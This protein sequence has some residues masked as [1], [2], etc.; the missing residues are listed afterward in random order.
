VST[1]TNVQ[2][3]G[4]IKRVNSTFYTHD[5]RQANIAN[6]VTDAQVAGQFLGTVFFTLLTDR[7]GGTRVLSVIPADDLAD[8]VSGNFFFIR[9]KAAP[10]EYWYCPS[11]SS[12][13]GIV[14]GTPVY[15]SR[16]ERTKFRIRLTDES[17]NGKGTIM[18]GTDEITITLTSANLSVGTYGNVNGVLSVG[19]NPELGLE[20]SALSRGFKAMHT[21]TNVGNEVVK[22]LVMTD[23]GEK[24]ELV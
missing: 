24:W 11:S 10:S 21:T 18:I 3:S 7:E 22:E 16:T 23:D 17:E 19:N 8:H 6:T 14:A 12:D 15:A 1:S 20:F 2:Y 9:S 13:G 4:S 5:T